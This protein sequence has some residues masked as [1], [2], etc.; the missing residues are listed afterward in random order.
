[1][2]TI[3]CVRQGSSPAGAVVGV[4]WLRSYRGLDDPAA[5]KPLGP[6]ADAIS[7]VILFLILATVWQG[8]S[9]AG[10]VVGVLFAL[11]AVGAALWYYRR[12][13]RRQQEGAPRSPPR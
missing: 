8:S 6:P 13:K 5:Q 10:A 3:L 1:V 2:I 4:Q 7:R 11:L 9:P 12:Y